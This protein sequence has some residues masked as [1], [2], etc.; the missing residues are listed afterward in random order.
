[1]DDWTFTSNCALGPC[2][3]ELSG[4]IDGQSFTT[5]LKPAGDGNYSGTAQINDYYYCGSNV[6][7]YEDSTLYI[8]VSPSAAHAVG[9]PLA[10]AKLSGGITWSIDYNPNGGCGGGQLVLRING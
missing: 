1:M 3:T 8:S 7:N 6:N 5:Q 4:Q 9:K 10:A 2:A